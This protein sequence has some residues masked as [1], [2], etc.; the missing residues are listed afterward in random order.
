MRWRGWRRAPRAEPEAGEGSLLALASLAL[1]A[2][3]GSGL[4]VAIF[5]LTLAAAD[6]WRG[7]LI[8]GRMVCRWLAL[9][10]SSPAA[11]PRWH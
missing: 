2:G 5:R 10:W 3:A 11:L 7:V 4:V 6:R 9:C 1:L 8:A